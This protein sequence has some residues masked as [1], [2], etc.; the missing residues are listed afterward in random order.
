LIHGAAGTVSNDGTITGTS[1]DGIRLASGGAVTNSGS[2]SAITGG[3]SGVD[4]TGPSATVTNDGTI[5]GTSHDGVVLSSGGQVTNNGS[6]A[7]ISGGN[8]GVYIDGAA[9][10]VT[11]DGTVTAKYNVG[12]DLS[13][14]GAVTN[15]G[16]A[17]AITGQYS[18]VYIDGGPGTVANDGTIAGTL[19]DGVYLSSGGLVTNTGTASVISG[20][21]FG[22][23]IHGSAGTVANDGTITGTGAAGVGVRFSDGDTISD[24]TLIDSGTIIGNSGTAVQLGAGNDVLELLPGASITG[25]VDGG[26]GTNALELAAG[27]G[28][29]RLTGLG[30]QYKNFSP[31]TID[32]DAAWTLFG[33]NTIAASTTLADHGTL[34]LQSG[35]ILADAATASI[36]GT[37]GNFADAIVSGAG[38]AWIGS[39]EMVVGDQGSGALRISS[40]GTVQTAGDASLDPSQGFDIAQ[41]ADVAGAV[42]VDGNKSLLSNTG[43]F[44]VGDAGFGTLLIENSG[45]VITNP[46]KAAGVAGAVIAAHAG[47]DGSGVS[48]TGPGS[49]WQVSG[50]LVVGNGA[51]G[52]LAITRG[53]K[54]TADQM[55]AGALAGSSGIVSV[56]GSGSSLSLTGQLTVGD[57][58]SAELS[59]LSGGTVNANAGDIGLGPSATGNVDI[60]GA[61]SRLNVAGNLNIGVAGVGVLTLGKDTELTIVDGDLNIGAEGVLNLFDGVIDPPKTI[62]NKGEAG[63]SGEITATVAIENSGTYFASQ[64]SLALITPLITAPLGQH[65]ALDIRTDGT[66][67]VNA[68]SVD[69]TQFVDFSDGTGVLN[70]G[71]LSGFSAVI[72]DFIAGDKII[73]GTS[74]A[75]TTYNETTDVLTLFNGSHATIGTLQFGSSVTGADLAADSN[76]DIGAPAVC[77]AAGTR[78]ATPGG[79]VPVERL[80]AGDQI[81]TLHGEACPVRWLGRRRI[82]LTTHPRPDTVAPVRIQRGAFANSVPHSDLL[83]SPDHAIFV[84]GM[85]ICAHQLING[86]TIR[87]EKDWTAVEYFHVKLDTHAILL[88]EGLPAESYLDTGNH[89]FFANAD[90]PLVLHPDL[91]GGTDYPTREAGSCMPF[92][93]DEARVRPVWQRLA[94]R[95]EALGHTAPMRETTTDPGLCIVAKGRMIRPLHVESGV[96]IFTLPKGA[97][98]VRLVSRAGSPADTRPWLEDRRCLGVYVERI[99]LRGASE[100]REIPLDHPALSEG[101]WTAEQDGTTLRRWTGGDAVLPLPPIDGPTMLEIR[102]GNAGMAY[103]TATDR[104]D[105][106]AA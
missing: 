100:M 13:S 85:L 102:A 4:I 99:L 48:V 96:H 56:V 89:G 8:F 28:A 15:S 84:D 71:T 57:I 63:G 70:I 34:L 81:T 40:Q 41:F 91:T 46:G 9:G 90:E 53:G 74:I 65:G 39:A 76:G 104:E 49:D 7:S 87:Q 86:T 77:F 24:N 66:L 35:T 38:A 42:T 6:A 98:E 33:T 17:S 61:G 36:S 58:A 52:S 83:L 88:A 31:I 29:G 30:T 1:G 68:G 43:R 26:L 92:V 105:R 95:A 59:I 22:A 19:F 62:R 51:A 50:Q 93:W 44:V 10:T 67:V 25:L 12:V 16:T 14:G 37:A 18:G 11:N 27:S 54:V 79:D 2:A 55:D 60:E 5:T 64:G 94:E 97:T 47:S 20:G 72:T 78:I 75:A 82:D 23:L 80:A 73:V 45:T 3:G 101:W 21:T 69:A 106:R 32:P 103:L